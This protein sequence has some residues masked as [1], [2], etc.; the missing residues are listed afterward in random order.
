QGRTA[1]RDGE[2]APGGQGAHG[3]DDVV[4]GQGIPEV[5]VDPVQTGGA[6]GGV[7]GLGE[8]LEGEPRGVIRGGRGGAI[9]CHGCVGENHLSTRESTIST[10]MSA[11]MYHSTRR[12][13]RCWTRSRAVRAVS[14]IRSS[15]APRAR[16]RSTIS[17]SSLRR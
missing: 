15:L 17:S 14:V 9:V 11:T 3:R 2:G 13:A 16:L 10:T 1:Q 8:E 12:V 7:V 6:A 4:Q 5:A